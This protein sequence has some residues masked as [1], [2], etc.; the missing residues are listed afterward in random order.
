VSALVVFL[1]LVLIFFILITKR[2]KKIRAE[3]LPYQIN[4]IEMA[5]RGTTTTRGSTIHNAFSTT[6]TQTQRYN[7]FIQTSK[8]NL[9]FF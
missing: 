2:L 1:T 6:S 9:Y 7:F 3:Q 4:A 5:N 8:T